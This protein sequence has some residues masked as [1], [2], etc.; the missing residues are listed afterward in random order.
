MAEGNQALFP[1]RFIT[2]AFILLVAFTERKLAWNPT[3]WRVNQPA[4]FVEPDAVAPA[5]LKPG[6][7]E[8]I[9]YEFKIPVGSTK[10]FRMS[11][12]SLSDSDLPA[13]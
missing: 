2:F 3:A 7:Y 5:G 11:S 6:G 13:K 4:T 12:E 9:P 1:A 8:I 10:S